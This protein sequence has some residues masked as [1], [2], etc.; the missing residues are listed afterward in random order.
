MVN[1]WLDRRVGDDIVARSEAS[2]PLETGGLLVGYMTEQG[3]VVTALIGAGP[4]A[5]ATSTSFLPDAQAQQLELNDIYLRTQG[6]DTYLGDWHSHPAGLSAMSRRDRRTLASIARH[7]RA[8]LARP[9]MLIAAGAQG[10][11]ELGCIIAE[12]RFLGV[13]FDS[14]AVRMFLPSAAASP[15]ENRSAHL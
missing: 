7:P 9:V 2:F 15:P 1:L 8:R 3:P 4:S 6:Q 13:S 5:T 12:R 11:W 10:R 14:I